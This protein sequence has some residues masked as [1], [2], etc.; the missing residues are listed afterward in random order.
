MVNFMMSLNFFQPSLRVKTFNNLSV[1]LLLFALAGCSDMPSKMGETVDRTLGISAN[2]PVANTAASS[3]LQSS[4]KRVALVIGNGNYPAAPLTN[5]PNDARDLKRALEAIGFE[6]KLAVNANQKQMEK[7][8]Q[9][10]AEQLAGAGLGLFYFAGH[11]TQYG[12]ENFLAPAGLSPSSDLDIQRHSISAGQV[13]ATMETVGTP[14]KIIILDACRNSPFGEKGLTVMTPQSQ[15]N[16]GAFIAYA[17]KP[18]DTAADG[19]ERNS[20]FAKSLL[21]FLPQGLPIEILF[22]KV[23]TAVKAETQGRQIPWEHTS[24]EGGNLCLAPCVEA[25]SQRSGQCQ[26]KVGEGLYEGECQN[27]IP[28]GQG[29][30]RYGDGEYYQGSFSNGMRHGLGTQ[31]LTDGTEME[32]TWMNGKIR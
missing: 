30:M 32:G 19:N 6:V 1:V 17:T 4:T 28:H 31:Y 24:L 11:G 7:L 15:Y 26:M 20:P 21:K 10:F 3:H 12:N 8:I 23:R 25:S 13:L 14:T 27:G 9:A 22:K 5:P 18:G 29:V 16:G 2:T